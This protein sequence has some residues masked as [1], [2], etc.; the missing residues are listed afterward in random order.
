MGQTLPLPEYL[1]LPRLRRQSLG[2]QSLGITLGERKDI[3]GT[4]FAT[5]TLPHGWTLDRGN[6]P[7]GPAR[8]GRLQRNRSPKVCGLRIL[9]GTIR[10]RTAPAFLAGHRTKSP[11]QGKGPRVREGRFRAP[12]KRICAAS[13]RARHHR[14]NGRS[15]AGPADRFASIRR[16][17]SSSLSPKPTRATKH[18]FHP[19][20]GVCEINEN[21]RLF[22]HVEW[23]VAK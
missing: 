2:L 6:E 10:Q 19:A 21:V 9:E 17:R 20:L 8:M 1:P 14:W 3:C 16:T 23:M 5:Y 15:V 18:V 4:S 22:K 12:G 11:H 13:Q 7:L